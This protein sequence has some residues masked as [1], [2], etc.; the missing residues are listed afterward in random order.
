[1]NYPS[2]SLEQNWIDDAFSGAKSSSIRQK[3]YHK[4][5]KEL[6]LR[7]QNLQISGNVSTQERKPFCPEAKIYRM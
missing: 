7:I 2:L 6:K 4:E 5:Q 3:I 1:M